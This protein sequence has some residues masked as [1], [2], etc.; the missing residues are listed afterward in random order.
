MDTDLFA[1]ADWQYL[2]SLLPP[3]WRELAATYKLCRS[4]PS[5][6][7]ERAKL[8]DPEVLLRLVLHHVGTESALEHTTAQ[9]H[10][11]GLVSVSKVA[12]HFRMRKVGPWLAHMAADINGN[13][14]AFDPQRW[15][16]YRVCCTDATAGSKPGAC[17][18]TF[19]VHYRIDARTLRPIQTLFSTVEGGEMLRRFDV[20]TGDLDLLDRAYCNAPDIAHA[21]DH[22]GDVIVRFNRSSLPLWDSRGRRVDIVPRVLRMQRAGRVKE[23][24]VRV[25]APTKKGEDPRWI[26]GRIVAMRLND[27]QTNKALARLARE[28]GAGAVSAED[29]AWAR[30]VVVF[31]TAPRSKLRGEMVMELYRLRW[32][33]E[34]QIKRDKS[35]G[36]LDRLP[37]FRDDTIEGWVSAKLLLQALARRSTE[38]RVPPCAVDNSNDPDALV[39]HAA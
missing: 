31:T 32:M 37:N 20:Q 5:S 6:G 36:G 26:T 14:H 2:K 34:L 1:N 9:A 4:M 27:E 13:D 3:Q 33:V 23:W 30:Y 39:E 17:G 15:A 8:K 12:L 28:K 19:R 21:V 24:G 10:A 11:I 35:I 25:A 29:R 16:G 7:G 22:G 18:T 38:A